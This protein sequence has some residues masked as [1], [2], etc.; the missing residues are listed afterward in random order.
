M[1]VP[2]PALENR[3]AAA[4]SRAVRWKEVSGKDVQSS[5]AEPELTNHYRMNLSNMSP[6]LRSCRNTRGES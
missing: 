4:Q 3:R 1:T 2:C 6:F 5:R